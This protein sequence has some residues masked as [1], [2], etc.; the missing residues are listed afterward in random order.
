[1]SE[2]TLREFAEDVAVQFGYWSD[3]AGGVTTGGLS[4]LE[5][6]FSILGWDDP[7]P[8]PEACCVWPKGCKK[9]GTSGTPVAEDHPVYGGMRYVFTCFEHSPFALSRQAEKETA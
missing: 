9:R 8:M 5:A 3:G 6:A 7:H 2:W 1:M 4:T